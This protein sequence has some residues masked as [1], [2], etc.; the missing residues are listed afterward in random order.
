MCGRK[1]GIKCINK[2]SEIAE[3]GWS[4]RLQTGWDAY[5]SSRSDNT[6][7]LESIMED[8]GL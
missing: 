7:E 6:G 5:K 3:T 8:L 2:P 1:L 4:S